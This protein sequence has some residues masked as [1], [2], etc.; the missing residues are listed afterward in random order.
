MKKLILLN[1]GKQLDYQILMKN[2][3]NVIRQICKYKPIVDQVEILDKI[4]KLSFQNEE[5]EFHL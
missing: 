4:R 1:H 3:L 2:K 5:V